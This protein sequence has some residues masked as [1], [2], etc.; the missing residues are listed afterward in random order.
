MSENQRQLHLNLFGNWHGNHRAA[1]RHPNVVPGQYWDLDFTTKVAQT[2]ERGL[3]DA[4]FFAGVGP[5]GPEPLLLLAQ[6]AAVTS[7]IGLAP[8]I[9][10]TYTDPFNTARSI[11]TLDGLSHGRAGFN[12]VTGSQRATAKNFGP[13]PHPPKDV[14]YARQEE[15]IEVVRLLWESWEPDAFVGD[16]QSGVLIDKTKV[17]NV[18]FK[19]EHFQ[20]DA[21]FQIPRSPQGRPVLFHAGDS[22][23]GRS[24]GARYADAIFTAQGTIE[25]ARE[26]YADFKRRVVEAGRRP[27][28]ALVVPG[29]LP[30]IG[31]TEAEAKANLQELNDFIDLDDTVAE[32][33]STDGGIDLRGEDLDKPVRNEVWDSALA[34]TSFGSRVKALREKADEACF[35][36]RE[37]VQ[38]NTAA[39]GHF[40]FVGTPEQVADEI[41]RWLLT[42]AADGFNYKAPLF[43]DGLEQFVDHVIPL[44]QKKGIYRREYTENTLRGHY[45]LPVPAPSIA[46]R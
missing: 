43:P 33:A 36:A 12:A 23:F 4:I 45:G 46:K 13:A 18:P 9:N 17:H 35:T 44:L 8:T 28:E 5:A 41:E 34:V 39:H 7:R 38:W 30:I 31:S 11:A 6:L 1:W 24:Q 14:R 15:Y 2:A 26:F 10:T 21:S 16:K 19:G 3:F 20:I 29:F 32:L 25:L 42:G 27:G 40:V 37:V 22:D